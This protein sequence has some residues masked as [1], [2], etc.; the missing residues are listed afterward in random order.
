MEGPAEGSGE[1]SPGE[2]TLLRLESGSRGDH[3][4]PSGKNLGEA[5]KLREIEE[6]AV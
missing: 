4:S 2:H 3:T 5:A 1:L 6:F